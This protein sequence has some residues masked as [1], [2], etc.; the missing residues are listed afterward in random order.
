ADEAFVAQAQAAVEAAIADEHFGVDALAEVLCLSRRQTERKIRALTGVSPADFIR[1][2]RL[3][4]AAS[5]LA[6]RYGTVSE[7]AYACG[8]PNA[9]YFARV[10]RERYGVAPSEWADERAKG[11]GG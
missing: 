4:R 6:Q 9:S 5:L 10:F 8:F 3:S 2:I 11:E 7:V 1:L